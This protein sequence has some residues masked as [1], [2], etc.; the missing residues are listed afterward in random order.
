[1]R[2][3]GLKRVD[4]GNVMKVLTSTKQYGVLYGTNERLTNK[5]TTNNNYV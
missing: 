2:L 3:R 4:R 1:M 5:T